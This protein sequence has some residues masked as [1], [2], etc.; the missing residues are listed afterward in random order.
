MAVKQSQI[1]GSDR[2]LTFLKEK[3]IDEC[4]GFSIFCW[5]EIKTELPFEYTI[6]WVQ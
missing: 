6:S 5:L 4:D 2:R 3:M 1:N